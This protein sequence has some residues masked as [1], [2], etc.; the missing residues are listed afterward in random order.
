MSEICSERGSSS[1]LLM[2]TDGTLG[3]VDRPYVAHRCLC[4]PTVRL[5]YTHPF[6]PI[7]P[8]SSIDSDGRP[9]PPVSRD[10]HPGPPV[11]STT[12][13]PPGSPGLD[14]YPCVPRSLRVCPSIPTRL[15]LDPYP[16]VR[17][18]LTMSLL[19]LVSVASTGSGLL[20]FVTEPAGSFVTRTN[21]ERPNPTLGV[22]SRTPEVDHR[23]LL[24]W[25][26]P[27][28]LTK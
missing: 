7:L 4:T 11:R 15:S 27:L 17:G 9:P 12:P 22:G 24:S 21:P 19:V 20:A 2:V 14:P 10:L 25:S 1:F 16:C 23:G 26:G 8:D 3:S 13:R 18:T 5:G 28:G 6:T